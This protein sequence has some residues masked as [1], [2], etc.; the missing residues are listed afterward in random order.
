MDNNCYTYRFGTAEFDEARFELRVSGLPVDVEPRALA[1]LAYLLRNVGTSL[2]KE[3]L[4]SQV[5]AGRVTVEKVLPNAINKLRRA[6]GAANAERICTL[7][8]IGYRLD[9]P[10]NRMA[11]AGPAAVNRPVLPAPLASEPALAAGKVV[12]GRENFVLHRQLGRYQNRQLGRHQSS[13]VWLAR[14]SKTREQ[15]VYKFALEGERLRDLKREVTVSRLLQES[16]AN[17]DCFVEVIDWNFE[18][19]PYFLESVYGGENLLDWA[20]AKLGAT[21]QQERLELFLQ[22]ADAMAAAHAIGVLHKDLKPANILVNSNEQGLK[23]QITDFGSASLL[24]SGRLDALGITRLGMTLTE[25]ADSLSG[26][27]LYIAPELFSGQPATTQSDVFA[28]GVLLYQLLSGRM[29]QPMVSGWELSIADELLARDLYLATNVNPEQRFASATEFAARLRAL[30][31]RRAHAT[32]L[33][34]AE[35]QARI[36]QAALARS[37]A[38]RPYLLALIAALV[39]GVLTAL[40]FQQAAMRSRNVAQAELARASALSAFLNEDLISRANPLVAT[41][42]P[43]ATLRDVLLAA[44]ARVTT[45]FAK[46]PMT[47]ATIRASLGGLF[48]SIDLWAEAEVETRLALE[49]YSANLSS[50]PKIGASSVGMEVLRLRSRLSRLL[51]KLGRLDDAAGELKILQHDAAYWSGVPLPRGLS[52]VP[53]PRDL[54][55]VPLPPD[56]IGNEARYLVASA[57]SSYH[58]TRGDFAK[59]V[60]EL[61][62][63]VQ[64]L[65]QYAPE[66]V[67]QHDALRTQLIFAYTLTQAHAQAQAEGNALISE[68]RARTDDSAIT[69]ALAKVALARSYSLQAQDDKALTLLLEAEPLIVERF[70]KGHSKHILLLGEL[71]GVAFRKPDWPKALLYAESLHIMVRMKMGEQHLQSQVTLVNWGRTLYESGNVLQ[72]ALRLR[73]AYKQLVLSQ[74]KASTQSQDAAYTLACAELELDNLEAAQVLITTLDSK[75]LVAAAGNEDWDAAM[76][77]L[78]GLLLLKRGDLAQARPLLKSALDALAPAPDEASDRFYRICAEAFAAAFED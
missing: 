45:R 28:L 40:S 11:L 59:A 20:D 55:A 53:L 65:D 5:W 50:I 24:D 17:G 26:T 13:E 63:A 31:A 23:V 38:N 60:P 32:R 69:V 42:G 37:R 12:P 73:A 57:W 68:A 39:A 71:I 66:N 3:E 29:A 14:H 74:G 54:S 18:T 6:L 33:T 36:A 58:L 35:A 75:T 9:G 56:L 30:E 21:D 46:Q 64:T 22:I 43:D 44:R 51:C 10:I 25:S 67:A 76:N 8:K 34:R 61:E 72:A 62:I 15:R 52:A 7:P 78:R 4:L 70:G 48:D 77:A 16:V 1:L 47:Q 49:L 27:P 41:K 2:S 19:A